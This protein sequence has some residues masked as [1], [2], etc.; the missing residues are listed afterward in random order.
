MTEPIWNLGIFSPTKCGIFC[1][2]HAKCNYFGILDIFIVLLFVILN[3]ANTYTVVNISEQIGL[4]KYVSVKIFG[5]L[6]FSSSNSCS[7]VS[8]I[9]IRIHVMAHFLYFRG[10]CKFQ[11]SYLPFGQLLI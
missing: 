10:V 11:V 8:F 9:T 2:P 7:D 5:L 1:N 4:L 6:C 3:L